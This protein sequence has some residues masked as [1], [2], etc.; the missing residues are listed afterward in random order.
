MNVL[1]K[2]LQRHNFATSSEEALIQADQVYAPEELTAANGV[3]LVVEKPSQEP[4]KSEAQTNYQKLP[5]STLEQ[6][7]FEMLLEANN[8]FYEKRFEELKASISALQTEIGQLR[9]ELKKV[10]EKVQQPS[11]Q[12]L[13]RVETKTVGEKAEKE[14]HPRQGN[15]TSDDVSIDKFFYFGA[16][17]KR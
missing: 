1:V 5:I 10:T 3:A 15:Y 17:G 11:E 7:R 8:K 2:E 13:A 14:A 16:G 12:P 6:K 4:I 9:F